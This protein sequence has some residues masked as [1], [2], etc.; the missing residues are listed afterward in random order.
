MRMGLGL[1][2]LIIIV[3]IL[4]NGLFV[5][6]E[7]AVISSRKVR[8]QQQANAGDNGARRALDLAERPTDFLSTVQIG[9]TLIAI[10]NG[11]IGGVTLAEALEPVFLRIPL[12]APYAGPI[13]L[14]L[15]V[16]VI[17]FFSIL[18]GELVPKRLAL[19]NPERIASAAAAP[20]MTIA[21][22]FKPLVL[23]MSQASDL[24]LWLLGSQPSG[25][26]PVTEEEIQVLLAPGITV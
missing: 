4:I 8:L 6:S 13:S 3:L 17:T 1:Q 15:V 19:H 2:I 11:A 9:I 21:R 22:I 20:M 14:T 26:P 16:L 23:L 5:I 12:L 24:V 25:E 10:L 18:V 7:A